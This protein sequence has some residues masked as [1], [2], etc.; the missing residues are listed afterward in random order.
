M[1]TKKI[2]S[3]LAAA[4]ISASA[5]AGLAATASAA[6]TIT[7]TW[8]FTDSTFFSSAITAGSTIISDQNEK[9]AIM[10][11]PGAKFS[12]NTTSV[13]DA[14]GT[15]VQVVKAEATA[16]NAMQLDVPD[17][18]TAHLTI[19]LT[20]G[21]T[22]KVLKLSDVKG[23]ALISA[24][25]YTKNVLDKTYECDLSCNATYYLDTTAYKAYIGKVTLAVTGKSGTVDPVDPDPATEYNVNVDSSPET[26]SYAGGYVTAS[27]VTAEADDLVTVTPI[28]YDHYELTSLTYNG[29][30]IEAQ[31]GV[32]SF[33]MPEADVNIA[34]EFTRTDDA[35]VLF[36]GNSTPGGGAHN[37][38]DQGI[39]SL[40]FVKDGATAT[41]SNV[42]LK[43][44]TKQLDSITI[45][46]SKPNPETPTMISFND[47]EAQSLAEGTEVG[48]SKP[49][50]EYYTYYGKTLKYNGSYEGTDLIVAFTS[51][52]TG[53]IG[54]Y[55]YVALNYVPIPEVKTHSE[56]FT[57]TTPLNQLTGKKLHIVASNDTETQTADKA[58]DD[59]TP[60]TFAGEGSAEIAV[61]IEGIPEGVTVT[62]SIID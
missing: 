5:F 6:D 56:G 21:S 25:D 57:F 41:F 54:N 55:W 26:L 1:K 29:T 27:T 34:A 49:G 35:T 10:T 28:A 50:A 47:G 40:S 43:D 16:S 30:E 53:F 8:D 31:N 22:G 9:T 42:V 2:L 61:I 38:A 18:S 19:Q 11:N 59:W 12:C 62:T 37:D 17:G 24:S 3:F 48:S 14:N 33:T 51:E 23:N 39:Y 4:A 20:S 44:A 15:A 13:T 58:F 45:Y 46:A 52:D 60:T 36:F 32:Y 7:Y